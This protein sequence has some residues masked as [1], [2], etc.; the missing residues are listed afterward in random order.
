MAVLSI[1]SIYSAGACLRSWLQLSQTPLHL[2]Q[3]C[4]ARGQLQALHDC[5]AGFLEAFQCAER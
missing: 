5:S 1:H 4:I 3:V 2:K